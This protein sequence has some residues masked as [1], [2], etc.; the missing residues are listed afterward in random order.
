[1]P[2]SKKYLSPKAGHPGRLDRAP[3]GLYTRPE[4][5]NRRMK[6]EPTIIIDSREQ[7]P[8]EFRNLPSEPG[9]LSAGDYSIKGLEHLIACERKS[10]DD[11]LS[12]VGI[13]RDRFRRELQRL[14]A[15]RFRALVVEA[16]YAQL[17]AGGW[18]S[19]IKPAC[20]LGSLAAWQCQYELPVMLCGS[21]EAAGRFAERFLFQCARCVATENAAVGV[22]EQHMA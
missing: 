19:K 9:T 11:L 3:A 20:V 5:S 6:I 1:M 21:H 7:L 18:R 14:R 15:Y 16:D 4:Q 8:W 12:C 2:R 22:V 10:L 17:E 13:H